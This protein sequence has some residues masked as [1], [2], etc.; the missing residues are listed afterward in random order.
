MYSIRQAMGEQKNKAV[1][2][3]KISNKIF[4]VFGWER[5]PLRDA[6]W[7]C[8]T[9]KH[10]K[11]SHPADVVFTYDDPF[12][13]SRPYILTDLKSYAKPTINW[14]SLKEA[15]ESLALSVDCSMRSP[16]FR[17]FYVK[18]NDNFTVIG[19]L[20]IYNHDNLY[21]K[22]IDE[23]LKDI[24]PKM[25][26]LRAGLKLSIVGPGRIN[27]LNTIANDIMVLN[28]QKKLPDEE[29]REWFYPDLKMFHPKSET[30]ISAPLEKLIGPWQIL[31]YQKGG[32]DK[33]CDGFIFYYD[34][35]GETVEEFAYLLDCLFQF[36][37]V[38]KN[39]D[40]CIRMPNA[41]QDAKNNFEKAKEVYSY[42][43]FPV[44][45]L[46]LDR[47]KQITFERIET[48]YSQFSEIDLGM[49]I[50]K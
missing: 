5:R 32:K 12:Q 19:M 1:I 4:S 22:A 50:E 28:S 23:M 45:D 37:L 15:L 38:K 49:E 8:V 47:L 48:V 13:R 44:H 17:D 31:K 14:T 26:G 43:F 39:Y 18:E 21:A 46:I 27:Y 7:D 34:G 40:I 36:Q 41:S 30:G 2:A 42:E 11:K 29:F 3:E 9:K 6:N 33:Q 20:F 10:G 24:S 35:K 25:I 16:S